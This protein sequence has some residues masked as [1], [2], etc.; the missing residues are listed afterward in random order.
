MR[1]DH[2]LFPVDFSTPGLAMNAEVQ[3]LAARFQ[4]QVTLLHVFEIPTSWYGTGESPLI[5]GPDIL[6]YADSERKRLEEYSVDVSNGRVERVSR[7]GSPAHH[8]VEYAKQHGV[9]LIV[10]ATHGYGP[11]RRFL[12]G[13][14]TMK[15]LHDSSC[16]VWM[17]ASPGRI[18]HD[19]KQQALQI[20]CSLELADESV[21]VLRQTQQ[22]AELFRGTVQIVHCVPGLDSKLSRHSP[23]LHHSLKDFARE[24]IAKLQRQAG[25]AFPVLIT[26]QSISTDIGQ[27]A[28]EFQ[29]DLVVTGRGR[30]QES[31]GTLRTHELEITSLVSCPVISFCSREEE[32]PS[33]E[34]IAQVATSK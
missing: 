8:I 32:R 21:P 27:A 2:I 18:K 15:V 11:W 34:T 19:S 9:D 33:V 20:L 16:P 31:F 3:W 22:L 14:V 24:E 10:M 12:L 13:S 1:F 30:I 4:S 6:A 5:T 7:E 25:T 17:H 28:Q 26:D 29:A 23:Q